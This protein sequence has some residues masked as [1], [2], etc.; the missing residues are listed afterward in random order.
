M[1]G[2]SIAVLTVWCML[3]VVVESMVHSRDGCRVPCNI[4]LPL[5]KM[6]SFLFSN[7]AV[8]PASHNCPIESNDPEANLGKICAVRAALGSIGR[9]N[10]AWCVD[11]ITWLFGRHTVIPFLTVRILMSG[12][13]LWMYCWFWWFNSKKLPVAPVSA[14]IGDLWADT[15]VG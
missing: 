10:S 8:H 5:W 2:I 1:V 9:S 15:V 3:G 6:Y 4:I 12:I 7:N 13:E 14:T 11:C